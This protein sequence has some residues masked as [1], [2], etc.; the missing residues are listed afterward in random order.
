MVPA[1]SLKTKWRARADAGGG[2]GGGGEGGGGGGGGDASAVGCAAATRAAASYGTA[3]TGCDARR[4]ADTSVCVASNRFGAAVACSEPTQCTQ[5]IARKGSARSTT[6]NADDIV[7]A[8]PAEKL[9][10]L[11]RSSRCVCRSPPRPT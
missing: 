11:A 7:G 5:T 4:R 6:R 2:G 3:A 1:A 8:A 9:G 10:Y